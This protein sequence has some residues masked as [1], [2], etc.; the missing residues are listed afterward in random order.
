MDIFIHDTRSRALNPEA[1]YSKA[2]VL[3]IP[4]Y[5]WVNTCLDAY[6]GFT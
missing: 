6:G 2:D 1:S 3:I 4:P 5:R